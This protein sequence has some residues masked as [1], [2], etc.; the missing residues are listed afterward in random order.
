M[1]SVRK[2][3]CNML[4]LIIDIRESPNF[5]ETGNVTFNHLFNATNTSGN[6]VLK[7][8]LQF[9]TELL[10]DSEQKVRVKVNEDLSVED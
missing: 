1:V 10:C 4:V 7:I 8:G 5:N 9:W 6:I 3:S 2:N